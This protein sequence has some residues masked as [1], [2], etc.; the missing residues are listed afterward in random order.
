MTSRPPQQPDREIKALRD[1]I[2]R[3]ER[4]YYVLDRPEI[5]DAEFD[6]LM[7]R[8]RELE[9]AWPQYAS[10]DSPTRRVGGE[11]SNTFAPVPHKVPMLSLDNCYSEEEFLDWH[12]RVVKG[13]GGEKFDLVVEPK[14][15]GLSCS[16]EYAGG[17]LVRAST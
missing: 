3:H 8:L 2:R 16:I 13:L 9:A 5:T 17:R 6:V 1:E 15:D 14:I 12:A 11:R 4:L 10:D 7:R